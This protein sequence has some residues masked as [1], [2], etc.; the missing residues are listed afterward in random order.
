[1]VG[2]CAFE[3]L[4]KE[5]VSLTEYTLSFIS[6]FPSQFKK[7]P[8]PKWLDGL[9]MMK[10]FFVKN[11]VVSWVCMRGNCVLPVQTQQC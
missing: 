3:G 6:R 11:Y 4:G 7:R 9:K 10:Y 1:M 5:I 2:N 8:C